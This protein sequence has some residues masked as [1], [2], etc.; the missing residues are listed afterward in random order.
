M[1]VSPGKGS[2]GIYGQDRWVSVI[3]PNGDN[4]ASGRSLLPVGFPAVAIDAGV[5]QFPQSPLSQVQK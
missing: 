4:A 1:N 2:S 5:L 3:H